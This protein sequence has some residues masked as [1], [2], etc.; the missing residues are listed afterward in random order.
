[1]ASHSEI[2]FFSVVLLNWNGAE[3]LENCLAS[4]AAQTFRSFELICV[5]NG[6]TDASRT[7]LENTDLTPFTGISATTLLL[8]V[9]TGFAAGMNTGIRRASGSWIIPL[10]VDTELADDFLAVAHDTIQV[11]ASHALIGAHV[12]AWQNG[13]TDTTLCTGVWLTRHMSICTRTNTPYD[14]QTYPCFGPAGCGPLIARHALQ[15]TALPAHLTASGAE[16]FYDERYFAYGEDVDL[17]FRMAVHGYRTL[18]VP[19]LHMWH[20]HSATQKGV[21]WHTKDRATLARIPANACATLYKNAP[22]GMAVYLL[23]LLLAVPVIMSLRLLISRPGVAYAPLQA[24]LRLARHF[25]YY[26][27]LR[28]YVRADACSITPSSLFIPPL[29]PS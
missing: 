20:R 17:Y 10:N 9:N 21:F 14:T 12:Y 4:L 27:R 5:D 7:W 1:M 2:P 8:P 13:R 16:E 6:S 18:Y 22:I 23:P 3:C 24:Y 11:H 26:H 15:A 28:R 25:Y 29:L 19:T